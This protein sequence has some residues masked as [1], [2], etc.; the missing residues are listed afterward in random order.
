M[1]KVTTKTNERYLY[2]VKDNNSWY[3]CHIVWP[4]GKSEKIWAGYLTEGGYVFLSPNRYEDKV[5][6]T[7]LK[8]EG[9]LLKWVDFP[10]S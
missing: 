6:Y 4:P 2:Y 10:N 9:L 8:V 1:T 5:L 3:I 7:P